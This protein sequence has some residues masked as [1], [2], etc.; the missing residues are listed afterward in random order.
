MKTLYGLKTIQIKHVCRKLVEENEIEAYGI[1]APYAFEFALSFWDDEDEEITAEVSLCVQ[2]IVEFTEYED[3][4]ILPEDVI[5]SYKVLSEGC[6]ELVVSKHGTTHGYPAPVVEYIVNDKVD[7]ETLLRQ[8]S[9]SQVVIKTPF[10]IEFLFAD[11]NA[12]THLIGD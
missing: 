7:P 1:K 5:E 9:E 3:E 12:H 4:E 6:D 11:V 2:E 8:V 10:G